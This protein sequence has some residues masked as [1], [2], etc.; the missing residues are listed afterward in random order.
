MHRLKTRFEVAL[1]V[2]DYFYLSQRPAPGDETAW[3]VIERATWRIRESELYLDP[4][5]PSDVRL[6][7]ARRV[8][9]AVRT[10][11][12]HIKLLSVVPDQWVLDGLAALEAHADNAILAASAAAMGRVLARRTRRVPQASPGRLR[13]SGRGCRR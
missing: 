13:T 6:R 7:S 11:M 3:A 12:R 5:K 2:W 9:N 1:Y 10:A 8:R 4:S